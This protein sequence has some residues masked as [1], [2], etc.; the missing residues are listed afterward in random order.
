MRGDSPDFSLLTK[1]DTAVDEN[2]K[3]ETQNTP[4]YNNG[5]FPL[6]RLRSPEK[7]SF[8]CYILFPLA[9]KTE[10]PLSQCSPP[11]VP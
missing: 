3:E 5:L 10:P 11:V 9:L 8:C 1:L 2:F 4:E 6:S 7:P